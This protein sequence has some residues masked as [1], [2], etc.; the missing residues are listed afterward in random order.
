MEPRFEW[1]AAK[2]AANI[3]KHRVSFEEAA[4]ALTDP[5]A[6]LVYDDRHSIAEDRYLVIARSER[7]RLLTVS[8][9]PRPKASRIIS[10]RLA[11]KRERKA[12]EEER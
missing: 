8:Y 5:L 1:D 3:R 4:T 10:A 11:T 7:D 6:V 12:Y 9:T 2:A